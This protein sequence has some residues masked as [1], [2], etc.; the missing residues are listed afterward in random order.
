MGKTN[1]PEFMNVR[2]VACYLGINEKK[3]YYSRENEENSVH[4]SYGR[5]GRF[6]N[7]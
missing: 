2:E 1:T 6:R 7:Y 4:E 3:I 5:S